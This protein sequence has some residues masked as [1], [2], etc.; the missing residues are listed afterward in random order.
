MATHI[1][2]VKHICFNAVCLYPY[3]PLLRCPKR[4]RKFICNIDQSIIAVRYGWVIKPSVYMAAITCPCIDSNN[5]WITIVSKNAID[6]Q[7]VV[8]NLVILL[9]CKTELCPAELLQS[10]TKNMYYGVRFIFV[11]SGL[12]MVMAICATACYIC[13]NSV[14][15]FILSLYHVSSL[16]T[17]RLELCRR[18]MTEALRCKLA[19]GAVIGI[20]TF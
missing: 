6:L 18:Q 10:A 4:V 16:Q 1:L 8:Q 19:L 12:K 5:F 11:L 3:H 15:L 14:F 9:G 13:L 17:S 2:S 7:N 20:E